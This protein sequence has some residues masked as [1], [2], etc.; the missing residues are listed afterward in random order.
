MKR[1][2]GNVIR[3]FCT[4]I[5]VMTVIF[6]GSAGNAFASAVKLSAADFTS[7]GGSGT[8]F[9][10][11]SQGTLEGD[12]SNPCLV[13]PVNIPGTATS[14]DKIVVFLTDDGSGALAPW[15][16][17][18]GLNMK[19]GDTTTY[20]VGDVTEGTTTLQ[21]I[22]I[23]VGMP[24]EVGPMVYQLGT[25]LDGGQFLYGVKVVYFP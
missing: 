13:A 10:L 22:Q 21:G 4:V 16:R 14:I 1:T 25:C 12:S 19:T 17:L 18:T 23:P 24:T 5:A 6:V 8:Y 2:K 20:F 3:L 15:F 9:K 11:F 7:D